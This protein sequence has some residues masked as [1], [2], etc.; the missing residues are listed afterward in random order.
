MVPASTSTSTPEVPTLAPALPLPP[1]VLSSRL[2]APDPLPEPPTLLSVVWLL[3]VL[4]PEV[5]SPLLSDVPVFDVPVVAAPLAGAVVAPVPEVE[6]P[7]PV[8]D[9]LGALA[10]LPVSA[11]AGVETDTDGLTDEVA[12]DVL[13]SIAASPSPLPVPLAPA[14]VPGPSLFAVASPLANESVVALLS[15]VSTE[16]SEPASICAELEAEP[17][18]VDEADRSTCAADEAEAVPSLPVLVFEPEVSTVTAPVI[19]PP[20]VVETSVS[21]SAVDSAVADV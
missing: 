8:S 18:P 2:T 13:L 14:E 12:D 4:V 3:L 6:V 15:V 16:P 1:M 19:V 11:A 5:L 17:S 10:P 21:P 20:P 9:A 7:A